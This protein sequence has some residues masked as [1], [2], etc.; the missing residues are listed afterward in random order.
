MS[1]Q[2]TLENAVIGRVYQLNPK[3]VFEVKNDHID[4]DRKRNLESL[5]R[6]PHTLLSK[7]FWQNGMYPYYT[8]DFELT[9]TDR[10]NDA[11]EYKDRTL[12]FRRNNIHINSYYRYKIN[13]LVVEDVKEK[14]KEKVKQF[15]KEA[16]GPNKEALYAPPGDY[17]KKGGILYRA[18]LK[19]YA[20][21]KNSMSVY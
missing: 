10:K 9:D 19:V 15:L 17:G 1:Y 20:Q 8:Y 3:D 21:T 13:E 2:V 12:M 11:K 4:A 6:E 5:V 14:K 16:I 18:S 7:G